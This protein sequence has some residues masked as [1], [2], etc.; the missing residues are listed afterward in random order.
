MAEKSLVSFAVT[1][2]AGAIVTAAGFYLAGKIKK[3][4]KKKPKMR[5]FTSHLLMSTRCTW[6]INGRS[7]SMSIHFNTICTLLRTHL[8]IV[9]YSTLFITLEVHIAK[10]RYY[11]TTLCRA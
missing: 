9:T 5:M 10:L 3:M 7:M 4:M 6:L 1:A 8:Y 11:H 2:G